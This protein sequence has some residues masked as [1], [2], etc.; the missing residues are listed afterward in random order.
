MNSSKTVT[1]ALWLPGIARAQVVQARG[2]HFSS[3]GYSAR[4]T[5]SEG[6]NDDEKKSKTTTRLEL[7]PEETLYLIERGSLLCYKQENEND[8]I[9]WVKADG[10]TPV[11]TPIT[12]QQAF[13]E[14]IG[15][16]DMTLERYEVNLILLCLQPCLMPSYLVLCVPET[17][18]LCGDPGH[19]PSSNALLSLT[20]A[21][22]TRPAT[23]TFFL[24]DTS[25]ALTMV[26]GHRSIEGSER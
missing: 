21:A 10:G 19:P 1:Y 9:D 6:S 15:K 16:E 13:A 26:M 22:P 18:R 25:A 2:V 12:V 17:P 11:G 8:P 7:L 4:R 3:L 24:G 14:M 23:P 5:T 20:P